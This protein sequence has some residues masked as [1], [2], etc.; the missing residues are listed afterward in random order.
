MRHEVSS[1]NLASP[2]AL[3][4]TGRAGEETS[5]GSRA[6]A[7]RTRD[8]RQRWDGRHR[9]DGWQRWGRFVARRPVLT[10][11]ACALLL[12]LAFL[13][14]ARFNASLTT[15]DV[16]I[17]GSQSHRAAQLVAER[18]PHLPP[19]T[20]MAVL[21]SDRLTYDAEPF[22]AL[23]Q[24][25]LDRFRAEDGV[26]AVTDP[27]Q[28]PHRLISTDRRTVL[29]PIAIRG[30]ASE[31][32]AL[33]ERLAQTAAGLTTADISV[34]VTGNSPLA[35]ASVERANEDLARSDAIALP[36]AGIILLVAFGS[37]VASALPLALGGIAVVAAFGLLGALSPVVSFNLFTKTAVTML[38]IALGIDYA[39]FM[40][41]RFREELA[42]APAAGRADRIAAVGR[43]VATAGHAVAFSGIAVMVSLAGLLVVD[44]ARIRGAAIGMI[45]AVAVMIAL[46]LT[47]MPAALALLGPRINAL[48]LPWARRRLR[49][50]DP[51]HSVW[52]RIADFSVRRPVLVA[53]LSLAAL[54]ALAAP[55]VGLRYGVADQ[56]GP[57]AETTAGRAYA[58]MS[59]Q[60]PAGTTAPIEVVVA[61]GQGAFDTASLDAIAR[62]TQA[63]ADDP[64]AA[65][66]TSITSVL[67]DAAG[68]HTPEVLAAAQREGWLRDAGSLVSPNLDAAVI[69]V[70]PRHGPYAK[71][72]AELVDR[73]RETVP[74]IGA[75]AGLT[76]LVGGAPAQLVDSAAQNAAATPVVIAAVL[77]AAALV[78][79]LAFRS[80]LLPATAVLMN[81]CTVGAACGAMVLIFQNGHGADLLGLNH[82]GFVQVFI[83]LTAFTLVFGLSMDYEVFLL[84]RMR[85]VW[86]AT[87]DNRAA[88]R[89]GIAHT[90]RVITAA[91]AIMV[92]V[93]GAFMLTDVSDV[94]QLGFMLALAILLDA[95]I[96][97]LLLM[98]ALMQL[99]G[100][101]NWWPGRRPS[102]ITGR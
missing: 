9:R 95:T 86:T 91:A 71:Q 76:V 51:E 102:V 43:T 31:R 78:L 93:F 21:H 41:S 89:A 94:Q 53:G 10:L 38:S 5:K 15:G 6:E 47:V 30:D 70:I 37:L 16:T 42:H 25:T 19:E 59:Q 92:A 18:F 34:E 64:D 101:W 85:E 40:V 72:T 84:S 74:G 65:E 75:A 26:T 83:P 44:S 49:T 8:G 1:S 62:M 52:A 68:A 54:L 48:A 61:R 82:D 33:A 81:L 13:G 88:V 45:A 2:H 69:S 79:F 67:D 87:G 27:A 24:A 7:R 12:P 36:V 20:D 35:A 58:T 60:F 50:P 97:R 73:L 56:L 63:A 98:P 96:V 55:V 80:V 17:E 90:A 99:F 14:A 39:L 32:Q 57:V 28:A 23:V 66:V 4:T 46:A 100:R 22:R 29:V 11:L 3:L 77:G